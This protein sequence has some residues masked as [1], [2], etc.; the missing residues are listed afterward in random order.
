MFAMSS[1]DGANGPR[2][3]RCGRCGLLQPAEN[4]AWRRKERSQRDNYCRPCR[5]DYKREHYAANRKRY[6]S[7][8]R[9]RKRALAMERAMYLIDLLRSRPCL[10]CGERDP[11]VLEFD[12]RG[13]KTFGISKGLRDHSR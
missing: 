5:A 11:L 1:A 12:H 7:Q 6:I 3:R 13:D 9:A 2:P 8:A 10:D 4:F